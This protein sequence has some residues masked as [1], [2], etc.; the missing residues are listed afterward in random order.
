[1]LTVS[2][3]HHDFLRNLNGQI[4]IMH[5]SQTDRLRALPYALALR[6][7]ALLDLDPVIDVVSCLYSPR[8]RPAT[9]PR[10]LIRSLILMYHFQE[11]SIQLWHDRL[12]Y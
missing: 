3:T 7:V 9:D 11:T 8:G 6:K 5:P 2:N 12:E 4:T 10:M 1:M